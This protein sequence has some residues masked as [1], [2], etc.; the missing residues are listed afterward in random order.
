S[1]M[2]ASRISDNSTSAHAVRS[3][4][5]RQRLRVIMRRKLTQPPPALPAR[6][7]R[8]DAPVRDLE[9]TAEAVGAGASMRR[10]KKAASPPRRSRG[11]AELEGRSDASAQAH[12]RRPH[13]SNAATD[14]SA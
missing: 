4:T 1:P 5:P 7:W 6:N 12:P 2:L 9:R 13:H 10:T 14:L 3:A 11:R 8:E